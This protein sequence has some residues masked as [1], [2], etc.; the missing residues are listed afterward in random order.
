MTRQKEERSAEFK[1]LSALMQ[2]VRNE[3]KDQ[4]TNFRE[5]IRIQL[6]DIRQ[7]VHEKV[8]V[9]EI[10]QD[11]ISDVQSILDCRVDKLEEDMKAMRDLIGRQGLG[12][13][14]DISHNS[15]NDEIDDADD[16]T[17]DETN[18][19]VVFIDDVII[20]SELAAAAVGKGI[21]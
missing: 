9:I 16:V 3:V 1:E 4:L 11:E 17:G 12:S 2:S 21:V 20:T 19:L 5:E 6:T 10:K 7:E 18:L 15:T 13:Q 8:S 14:S